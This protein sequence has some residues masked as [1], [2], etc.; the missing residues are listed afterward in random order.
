MDRQIKIKSMLS[1][2]EITD[3][4]DLMRIFMGY[5]HHKQVLVD[6]SDCGGIYDKTDIYSKVPILCDEYD[7][8]DTQIYLKDNW[9]NAN[10]RM[11]FYKLDINDLSYNTSWDWLMPVAK[12]CSDLINLV[13]DDESEYLFVHAYSINKNLLEMNITNLWRAVVAYI[14]KYNEVCSM[15]L[16]KNIINK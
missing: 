3:G 5:I 1:K 7:D 16:N 4:N 13:S 11:F 2:K 9:W 14:Q 12:K 6:F 8:D 10:S 15:N